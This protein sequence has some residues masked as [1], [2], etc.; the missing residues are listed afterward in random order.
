MVR[1]Y[2][3]RLYTPGPTHV[4]F[5]VRLA[6]IATDAHHRAPGFRDLYA[7]VT[8]G[9]RAAFGTAGDVLLMAG[10]GSS[11][12]E[13]VVHNLVGPGDSV[14]VLDSGKYGRRWAELAHTYHAKVA[15]YE[16]EPGDT[17]RVDEFEERLRGQRPRHVFFTHCETSTGVTHDIA[18]FAGMA[19]QYGATVVLDA[20]AT[21]AAEPVEMDAWGVDLA[22]T[23]SHKG[24]MSP[25]GAAFVAVHT[26][27]WHTLRTDL[28]YSSM[29]LP[30]MRENARKLT[31]ANTPPISV[32]LAVAAALDLIERESLD[33]VWRRH[34]VTAAACRAGVRA[35]GL[36][37]FARGTPSAALTSVRLPAHDSFA[38]VVDEVETRFGMRVAGGQGE[39]SGRIL[40]IGHIGAISAFD[41]LP[42]FAALEIVAAERGL[43]ARPGDAVA[44]VSQCLHQ[45]AADDAQGTAR[46]SAEPDSAVQAV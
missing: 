10:S 8:G 14:L 24:L 26:D 6:S 25:P 15:T 20:M 27:A 7:R 28:G 4:P 45:H 31:T 41:L 38:D 44:A 11:A 37:L 13:A 22:V 17:F 30:A 35:L 36:G 42:L 1:I 12:M 23:A 29:S 16:V 46:R 19:K 43:A 40:R 33:E 2:E 21:I 3:S 9:L 32:L 5:H 34:A 39:L 18:P